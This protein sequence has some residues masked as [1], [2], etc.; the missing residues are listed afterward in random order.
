MHEWTIISFSSEVG[1]RHK[2]G[3]ESNNDWRKFSAPNYLPSSLRGLTYSAH[4]TLG[5]RLNS[6]QLIYSAPN[7]VDNGKISTTSP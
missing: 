7:S 5:N 1:K 2:E 3:D 6:T 4:E